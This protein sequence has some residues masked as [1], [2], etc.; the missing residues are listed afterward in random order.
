VP[1]ASDDGATV[2]APTLRR[3]S[4][5]A[6]TFV[7]SLELARQGSVA[8]TQDGVFLPIHVRPTLVAASSGSA[9][10]QLAGGGAAALFAQA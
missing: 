7:A 6:S 2:V 3:R 1:A 4:A 10:V 9:H 8:L 5:W